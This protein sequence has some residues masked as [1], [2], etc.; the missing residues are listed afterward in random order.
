[1]ILGR[2]RGAMCFSPRKVT[3]MEMELVEDWEV[4]DGRETGERELLIKSSNQSP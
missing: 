4:K 2:G 3:G 1:M